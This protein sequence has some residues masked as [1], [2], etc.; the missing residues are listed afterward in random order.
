[1]KVYKYTPH[2]NLF[3]NSSSLK[4]TPSFQL[5][6][7]FETKLTE[8]YI[9]RITQNIQ[10]STNDEKMIKRIRDRFRDSGKYHGVVSLSK[11]KCDIKMLSHYANDHLGGILEF[12]ISDI[13]RT[14]K[15]KTDLFSRNSEVDYNFGEV[16]YL[17][18][19]NRSQPISA[20]YVFSDVCFEKFIDWKDE[21]EV[22]YLSDYR[23]VDYILI[24]VEAFVKKYYE[25][26]KEN[27]GFLGIKFVGYEY[28]VI[29]KSNSVDSSCIKEKV[30]KT[31]KNKELIER[32]FG[33]S[34]LEYK[35]VNGVVELKLEVG[36]PTHVVF[37]N[38]WNRLIDSGYEFHPMI[39]VDPEKLTG[40][41]LGARFSENSID[42]TLFKKYINLK[43][44]VKK[45]YISPNDFSHVLTEIEA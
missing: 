17:E 25:H 13:D 9:E 12:T 31:G 3:L 27:D 33:R 35:E 20:D 7:P 37:L 23:L 15:N 5:N 40:I 45:L 2:I 41:Y 26:L 34:I 16:A 19:R 32:F 10:K 11:K 4:L 44:N 42:K 28:S 38:A 1:M 14:Y 22:R 43:G 6:D 8:D 21:E 18:T 36:N 30:V 24:P 39:N 29:F